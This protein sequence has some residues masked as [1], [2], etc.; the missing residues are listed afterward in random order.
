MKRMRIPC[1][2]SVWMALWYA[3]CSCTPESVPIDLD[4]TSQTQIGGQTDPQ[5]Q[6]ENKTESMTIKITA[7]GRTF[8]ADIEETETGK[9]FLAKLPLT[10]DMND[11]NGNEK[12]SYGVSL[13]RADR[14][15]ETIAAGDLML[16]SGSCV[17]LFYGSAGGYSYTRIGRLKGTEGLKEALGG[18]NIRVTFEKQ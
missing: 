16:Y 9:A 6:N 17:V 18:G 15:F 12:Y 7:G 3:L 5:G 10:L 2:L 1:L 4:E 8:T 11:L 14:Y 13:P